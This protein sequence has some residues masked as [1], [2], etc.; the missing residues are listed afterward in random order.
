MFVDGCFWHG[1]PEHFVLPGTNTAY[2]RE[3]IR[4]NRKRDAE[5]DAALEREGWAVVR[6]WEHQDLEAAA[7]RVSDHLERTPRQALGR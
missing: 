6:V 2:W 4:G 1:C 7:K 3:K 5:T